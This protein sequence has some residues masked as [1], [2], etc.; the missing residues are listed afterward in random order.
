M[1][2]GNGYA[3]VLRPGEHLT[4][5]AVSCPTGEYSVVHQQDGDV[6]VYRNAD[7]FAVWATGTSFQNAVSDPDDLVADDLGLAFGR[8]GRLALEG[9]G[10]LVVYSAAGERR[11]SSGPADEPV[12]A[13]MIHD[14]GKLV[15]KNARGHVLWTTDRAPRRWDGWN[16]VTDGSRLRRGQCLRNGSLV[17]DN[18]EYAFVVGEEDSAYFCR[19]EG[20]VLWVAAGR[21]GEGYELTADG[22]LVTRTADGIEQPATALKISSS[23]AAELAARNAAELLVT[24]D[25]RLVLV[26]D[27]GEVLWTM[28]APMTRRQELRQRAPEKPATRPAPRVP[29]GVPPLPAGEHLPVVRTDFSDD[30]A[31]TEAVARVGGEY[32]WDDNDPLSIE[33]TPIDDPRYANLS[34]DQVAALAPDGQ[35]PMLVIA[36]ERTMT[37]PERHLLMVHLGPDGWGRTARA[38]AA[39]VVEITINLWLSNL[40]WSDYAGDGAEPDDEVI[41]AWNIPETLNPS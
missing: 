20:D 7:Q 36:D 40:D 13:L 2:E 6:V 9:N 3:L 17:S 32:R 1:T 39:A 35:W 10:E 23:T 24:D 25:G 33:V 19:T 12:A 5:R 34:P 16:N 30:A 22:R 11:W 29:P 28:T 31:W 27:T 21:A 38:T 14:W 41:E 4:R 8:P 37:T 15:L 18:G 26:D